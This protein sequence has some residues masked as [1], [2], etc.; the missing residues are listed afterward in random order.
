MRS[1]WPNT[2]SSSPAFATLPGCDALTDLPVKNAE[3]LLHFAE[4]REQA[5][6][7]AGDLHEAFADL[8]GVENLQMSFLDVPD[9]AVDPGLPLLQLRNAHTGIGLRALDELP[10]QIEHSHHSK[11]RVSDKLPRLQSDQPL[12]CLLSCRRNVEGG[13]VDCAGVILSKPA[14]FVGSPGRRGTRAQTSKRPRRRPGC[15]VRTDG[16]PA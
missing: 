12:Q 1:R 14:M 11:T 2:S 9:F 10:E 4:V 7:G 13:F 5:A 3:V 15:A 16:H 6:R 8:R